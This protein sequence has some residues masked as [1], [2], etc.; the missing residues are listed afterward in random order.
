MKTTTTTL[1][2]SLLAFASAG[3]FSQQKPGTTTD[4]GLVGKVGQ[5]SNFLGPSPNKAGEAGGEGV[6]QATSFGGGSGPGIGPTF[7][8]QAVPVAAA[9][10]QVGAGKSFE[11]SVANAN[12]N[13]QF[14]HDPIPPGTNTYT[15]TPEFSGSGTKP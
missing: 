13:G 9:G 7:G 2:A 15:E 5:P 11:H 12:A 10:L 6:G 1:I 14:K 3:P 8:Q 4:P